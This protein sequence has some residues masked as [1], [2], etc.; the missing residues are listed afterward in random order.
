MRYGCYCLLGPPFFLD[1]GFHV[2]VKESKDSFS[3]SPFKCA[4]SGNM[5]ASLRNLASMKVKDVPTYVK[6]SLNGEKVMKDTWSWLYKYNEKYIQ[7][8]SIKPLHDVMLSV[9]ILGY[10]IAWPTELRHLRHAEEVAK[11]GKEHH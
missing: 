10:A 5:A 9:G 3:F 11:H 8:G 4:V 6:S 1:S 2:I 7:T